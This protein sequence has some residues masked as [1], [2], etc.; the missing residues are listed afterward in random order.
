MKKKNLILVLGAVVITGA[1]VVIYK[2]G[3]DIDTECKDDVDCDDCS[4]C[5]NE[6]CCCNTI[7]KE[8]ILDM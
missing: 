3:K 4:N 2:L 6:E 5:S 7:K 1:A 8:H